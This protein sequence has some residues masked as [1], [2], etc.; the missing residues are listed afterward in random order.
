MRLLLPNVR[1]RSAGAKPCVQGVAS[2]ALTHPWLDGASRA[3][4]RGKEKGQSRTKRSPRSQREGGCAQRCARTHAA[5]GGGGKGQFPPN[6]P[7][8][9]PGDPERPG[10]SRA[11]RTRRHAVL[12]FQPRSAESAVRAG[13]GGSPGRLQRVRTGELTPE[14]PPGPA[15]SHRWD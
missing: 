13:L 11:S 10:S 15:G 5:A 8:P 6:S 1:A 4:S 9:R 14:R 7:Q 2:A 12:S 3:R